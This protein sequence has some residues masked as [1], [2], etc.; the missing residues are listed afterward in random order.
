[1]HGSGS[2]G[3][4]KRP[5]KAAVSL[6]SAVSQSVR[7]SSR[8]EVEWN[9]VTMSKPPV[10]AYRPLEALEKEGKKLREI[11]TPQRKSNKTVT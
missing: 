4:A 5:E 8:L 2:H 6:K 3:A 11:F 7:R 9:A 1:V 10:G